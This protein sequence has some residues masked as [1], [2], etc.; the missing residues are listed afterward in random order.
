MN[1]TAWYFSNL[2]LVLKNTPLFGNTIGLHE[3]SED[4]V[5]GLLAPVWLRLVSLYEMV[6]GTK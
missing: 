3:T 6:V 4:E 2:I 5:T 1:V